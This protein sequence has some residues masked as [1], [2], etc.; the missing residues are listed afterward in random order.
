MLA[1]RVAAGELPPVAERL[2]DN[3]KVIPVFDTIGTYGGT[4]R[5][6]D[7]LERLDTS[8]RIRHTG[9]F[10]YNFTASEFQTDLAESFAWS[11][12]N[13]TLT[14]TLRSGHRWSDGD[15]FDTADIKW[16]W[17]NVLSHPEVSP[18]GLPG[19]LTVGG[20]DAVLEIIDDTSY[21][22]TWG[23][24]NPGAMDRLGRTHFSGDNV[25]YGPSHY[26]EQF[27]AD[28]NENAQALAEAEGFETWIDLLGHRKCQCY[29]MT[30][31]ALDRPF[32]DSFIPV[33]VSSDRILIER[34]PYFHQVDPEGNQL[35]Y[36]DFIEVVRVGDNELYSLKI[37]AG[38]FDFGARFTRTDDL[39]LY[40]Q[41]EAAG[42]YT[43]YTAQSLRPSEVSF[44]INQNYD[45]PELNALFT[46]LDFRAALSVAIDREEMNDV[47]FFGL[48]EVHP[49]TPLKTLPWFQDE[50]Y[51]DFLDFDPE[52]ANTLLDG[53]GL[54][55]R[56]NAGI[57]QLPSGD[58]LTLIF[59][60]I[61]IH[62]E[63][64][65]LVA[66]QW[67]VNIGVD[68]VC[69]EVSFE[70][71]TE[72]VESN[73]HMGIV[74]HIGRATL[75]GRGTPD[76]FAFDRPEGNRWARLW[77]L[78]L[79]TNG[80]AGIE[81]PDSIKELDALWD[82]FSLHASDSQGAIEVG[83][84]YYSYFAEQLPVIPTVGLIPQPIIYSNRL[85]N[86]PTTDIF[87]GSD[88]NFYAPFHVEQWFIV[89]N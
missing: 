81:P 74:W 44:F 50:W 43:T 24:P 41:G 55:E 46:N 22:I 14:L 86:V 57:R 76:D 39:Q 61:P 68:L 5:L 53:L 42:D 17:D 48:G 63:R 73:A 88:T 32:L 12:D 15:P 18:S 31:I 6:G 56:N 29:A 67:R 64:C 4:L 70:L 85:R 51:N 23:Q 33:E 71:V 62:I 20:T 82:E 11:N 26:L 69:Q 58:Q 2:P 60:T 66:N 75:F 30:S 84:R 9:L 79:T 1:E 16:W 21:S 7:T 28:F 35:P 72:L 65:E 52:R 19:W 59:P 13:Q 89:D 10:R 87:W 3:P 34:N 36:L 27:H 40:R 45:D 37:S 47:F 77:T 83:G 78:W 80:E 38:D 25:V 49:A 54:A 8:L